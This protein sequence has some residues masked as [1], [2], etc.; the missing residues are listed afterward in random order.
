M[1]TLETFIKQK[2]VSQEMSREELPGSVKT[3]WALDYKLQF[4]KAIEEALSTRVKP[5]DKKTTKG[6]FVIKANT[7]AGN[8]I[9]DKQWMNRANPK[10]REA[11]L[12]REEID[13][14]LLSKRHEQKEI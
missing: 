1:D 8:W 4:D 12:L 7:N 13:L 9:K 6:K 10:I 3:K 14:H 11:E 2:E 5:A